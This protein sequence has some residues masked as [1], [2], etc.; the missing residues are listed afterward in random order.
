MKFCNS[1]YYAISNKFLYY[2]IKT[3]ENVHCL[4]VSYTNNC[5]I[6]IQCWIT[7]NSIS[8]AKRSSSVDKNKDTS[9]KSGW[10]NRRSHLIL[11]NIKASILMTKATLIIQFAKRNRFNNSTVLKITHMVCFL[12]IEASYNKA[13]KST[14]RQ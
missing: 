2:K 7:S 13:S 4:P 9:L 8:V 10:I 1:L 5:N 3:K 12:M 6:R 14:E 11:S